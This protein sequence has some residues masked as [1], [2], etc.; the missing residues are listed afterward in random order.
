LPPTAS[1]EENP[2]LPECQQEDIGATFTDE[3]PIDVGDGEEGATFTDEEPI[4]VGD[5]EEGATFTDE[6]P[7][8]LRISL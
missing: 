2:S 6:E 8:E 1:C 3:E 4:D 5:G 7:I